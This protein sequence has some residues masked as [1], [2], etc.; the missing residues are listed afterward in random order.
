MK[1]FKISVHGSVQGVGFRWATRARARLLGINGFVRNEDDGSVYVE[2]EGETPHIDQFLAW[3][4]RGPPGARVV[5]TE[6]SE[7]DVKGFKD[8]E[9][10]L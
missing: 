8:F 6:V 5:S 9:I 3:C 2:A 7:G 10:R 4:R 1:H